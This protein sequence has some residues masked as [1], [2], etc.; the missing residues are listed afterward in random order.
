M[1]PALSANLRRLLQPRSIAFLGGRHAELA[2]RQSRAIGFEGDVWPVNPH[3]ESLAGIPCYPGVGDLPEAPDAALVAVPAEASIQAVAELAARGAGGAVCFATGFAE[4]GAEGKARQQHLLEAAGDLALVGPNCI[5]ILNYLDGAA[6]WP[7]EQGGERCERGAAILSQSGNVAINLTMQDRSLPLAYVISLGNQAGLG[8]ADYI[9]GLLDDP[10]VSAI[11][12]YLEQL[13]D[14][15]AFE[16]AALQA[17]EQSVP[18]VVVKLGSSEAGERSVL[19]HTSALAGSDELYQALFERLGILR[20]ESPAALLETLKLFTIG[21]FSRGRR[22]LSLSCSGGEA[23]LVGDL[24]AREQLPLD[25]PQPEPARAAR[26]GTLLKIPAGSVSNPLDYNTNHWGDAEA[27]ERAFAEAL[28]GHDMALLLLDYPRADR[29]D[30]RAWEASER[31]WAAA[32][33]DSDLLPAIASSLP[34]NLTAPIRRRLIEQGI[35]PLQGL[36]EALVA[37]AAAG[38]YAERREQLLAARP[39]PLLHPQ[40]A[41]TTRGSLLDEAE[42]K[43]LLATFGLTTPRG[44]VLRAAEVPEAAREMPPPLVLKALHP[45]LAHKTEAGAVALDLE[46]PAAVAEAL[47]AMQKRLAAG[48]AADAGFLL[49]PMITDAVVEMILGL[50][51]SAPFGPSLLIGAGGILAELIGDSA[52]LLL[53][54]TEAAIRAALSRLRVARLLNGWRGRP[55][56]DVEA[57]VQAALALTRFAEAEADRLLECDVNPLLVRP[58]GRGVVVADA[59]IRLR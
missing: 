11:G 25:L 48:P 53:P 45:T 43:R 37:L 36:R 28:E 15:P 52:S 14:V 30:I 38:D 6:L 27:L 3:R 54:T 59:L 32:V 16:R 13:L 34:E 8:I 20:V 22:L 58:A 41:I 44:R 55:A 49:E 10:R 46:D 57:L 31:A 5:G 35:T 39:P 12:I 24:I 51:L 23:A 21:G 9:E 33:R 17:L 50:Q 47:A 42:A 7:D 19:S 1:S 40:A 2:L 29:G 56:G 4:T 18:I 26:L